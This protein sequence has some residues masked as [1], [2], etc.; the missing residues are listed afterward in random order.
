[1][2][3]GRVGF[4]LLAGVELVVAAEI[5]FRDAGR[6]ATIVADGVAIITLLGGGDFIVPAVVARASARA[7]DAFLTLGT[8]GI[9]FTLFPGIE[10]V[11]AAGTS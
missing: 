5:H 3:A 6:R 9:G 2:G 10:L 11:V 1:M 8:G 4:T 7:G